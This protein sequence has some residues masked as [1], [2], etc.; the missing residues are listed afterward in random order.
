MVRLEI[1]PREVTR[2]RR[3]LRRALAK[4]ER[5]PSADR[6]R[7]RH[8]GEVSHVPGPLPRRRRGAGDG[9]ARRALVRDDHARVRGLAGRA[10]HRRPRRRRQQAGRRP[11]AVARFDPARHSGRRDDHQGLEGTEPRVADRAGHARRRRATAS[12][13]RS[14]PIC[15]RSPRRRWP[16]PSSRMGAEGGDIVILDPHDGEILAMASRRLDPRET[17]ATALTEPFEP[18]STM[19]PFI[20][21]GLLDRGRVTDRDS[22]DTGNGVFEINGREIHDEHLVGRAPLADVLRWSSNI[23][24]VKFSRAALARARSSRRCAIS[25]SERRPAFRI[26]RSRGGMLRAPQALVEAV[27]ELAGDGLRDLRDAA[28]TRVGVR[29]VRQRRRA[30]RAGAGEGDRRAGRHGSLPA[31]AA[32]RAT[33]DVE[34]ASADKCGTCCSTS[35]TRAR[36]CRRRSTTIMLAGKTGTPRGTVRGRYVRGPLQSELRRPVS[37]RQSAVRDRREAHRAAELDLCRARRRRR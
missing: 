10:G 26:R 7:A 9:A 11:R 22:V 1:A 37:R 20:A 35:S 12:C 24:I 31:Q 36:R 28:A 30:D 2:A 15:R 13:S 27:G 4:L 33:R 18:G 25:A 21:A 32:R 14:T 29:G 23:G 5:R 34:A 6:A 3:K 16:T 17:S 8:V 19:K